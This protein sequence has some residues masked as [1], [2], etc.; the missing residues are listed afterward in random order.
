MRVED[1]Y[2]IGGEDLASG[3][4]RQ[5]SPVR[6]RGFRDGR[7]H[8]IDS[9]DS[10]VAADCLAVGRG[11][12]LQQ[13]AVRG[14]GAM[15]CERRKE[16]SA[17]CDGEDIAL[18]RRRTLKA[19]ES[20]GHAACVVPHQGRRYRQ[21]RE[22]AERCARECQRQADAS[23]ALLPGAAASFPEMDRSRSHARPLCVEDEAQDACRSRAEL[24]SAFGKTPEFFAAVAEP[25]SVG[26]SRVR[27]MRPQLSCIGAR[28]DRGWRLPSACAQARTSLQAPCWQAGA[29]PAVALLLAVLWAAV[30]PPVAGQAFPPLPLQAPPGFPLP[31]SFLPGA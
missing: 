17:R 11:Q 20:D 6:C 18:A 22:K 27:R 24:N 23:V 4:D 5:G 19:V 28:R 10:P 15:I 12:L 30:S 9:D 31:A 8:T 14:Q 1:Q 7:P 3:P 16:V 13:Q 26:V 25:N 2:F 29:L 21:E